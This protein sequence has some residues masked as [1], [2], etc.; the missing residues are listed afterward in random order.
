M[1]NECS[2]LERLCDVELAAADGSGTQKV[3]VAHLERALRFAQKAAKER[4]IPRALEP[5]P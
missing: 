4:S 5:A 3:R 1:I 2:D